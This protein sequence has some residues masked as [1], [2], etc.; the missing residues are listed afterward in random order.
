MEAIQ[1]AFELV[2][3]D[4]IGA[5]VRSGVA[6][7]MLGRV[8]SSLSNNDFIPMEYRRM[9]RD[10]TGY[11]APFGQLRK[12]G[13]AMVAALG[14]V[15]AQ[16]AAPSDAD[17][18]RDYIKSAHYQGFILKSFNDVEPAPLKAQCP[19]LT[20]DPPLVTQ[21]ATFAQIGNTYPISTGRWVQ[22]A[23]LNRCGAKAIR[24]LFLAA[25]PRDGSVHAIGLMP[26]AFPGDLQLEGDAQRIVLSGMMQVARC[27][28]PRKVIVLDT[29]LT[30][31][32]AA[33]GW[34]EV[35]TVQVCGRMAT[36]DV[37]YTADATGMNVAAKNVRVK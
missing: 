34:S 12:L 25:D 2:G 6:A 1:Q 16:A 10:A 13:L 21:P 3:G 17:I 11:H 18:F 22:R 35:W 29:R 9:T 4:H 14:I 24:R 27:N 32:A 7:G 28:D 37:I 19:A 31:P 8:G 30:R 5:S 23:M 26:G 36:A 20:L 15:P 33:Q